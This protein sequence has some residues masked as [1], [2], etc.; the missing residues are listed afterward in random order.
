MEWLKPK[1]MD[2]SPPDWLR[3]EPDYFITVCANPR[4]A[5]HFCHESPGFAILESI[6]HRNQIQVWFCHVAVLMPD[7]IHL[8]ISFADLPSFADVMGSWKHYLSRRHGIAWQENFFDHRI[9]KEE[10]FGEKV[11]YILQNPVRAGL[12]KTAEEWRYRWIAGG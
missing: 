6:Q 4:G 8:M 10:S 3:A 9:R 5:N 11:D 12:V 7:H 2:H 1:P